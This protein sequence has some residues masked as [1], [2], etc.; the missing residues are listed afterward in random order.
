MLLLFQGFTPHDCYEELKRS[1]PTVDR[2]AVLAEAEAMNKRW[3]DGLLANPLVHKARELA[4]LNYSH[5]L[6]IQGWHGSLQDSEETTQDMIV[7]STKKTTIKVITKKIQG[8][9]DPRWLA[10][11][12]KCIAK[13]AE[14][15]ELTAP[16]APDPEQLP[17][18]LKVEL[19]GE[20]ELDAPPSTENEH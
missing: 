6:A 9:G 10:E 2:D 18:L 12:N 8:R 5:S 4:M 13:R 1:C 20:V 16:Q 3:M 7:D 14:L 17:P 19:F 15:L 11:I